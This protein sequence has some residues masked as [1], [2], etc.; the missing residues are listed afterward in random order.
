M[1]VTAK[2]S[3]I[4]VFLTLTLVLMSGCETNGALRTCREEKEKLRA[5]ITELQGDVTFADDFTDAVWEENDKLRATIEELKKDTTRAEE[6]AEVAW[7]AF[8]DK[9]SELVQCQ[10]ALAELEEDKINQPPKPA[11]P[12]EEK[13]LE[14]NKDAES[15]APAP[16]R[17]KSSVNPKKGL[18][19]LRAMQKLSIEREKAKS[20]KESTDDKSAETETE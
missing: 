19:Q 7:Q 12:E 2:V 18:E 1:K 6:F 8:K 13:E 16:S 10:N 9:H 20:A 11:P 17:K 5:D 14:Q 3:F 15:K 4:M